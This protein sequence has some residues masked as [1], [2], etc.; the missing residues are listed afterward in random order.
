MMDFLLWVSN[1]K[2][3]LF[4]Q[5]LNCIKITQTLLTL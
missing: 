2:P 1:K 5:N 3:L 4:Q